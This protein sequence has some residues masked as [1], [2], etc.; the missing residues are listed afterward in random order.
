MRD[1]VMAYLCPRGQAGHL[2]ALV[3]Q[4]AQVV[5]LALEVNTTLTELDLGMNAIGIE[6]ATQIAV[7][8]AKNSTLTRLTLQSRTYAA[9]P[10]ITIDYR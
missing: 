6:G 3:Q 2:R 1:L 4:G 8:L 9:S 7:A 10:S 5:A